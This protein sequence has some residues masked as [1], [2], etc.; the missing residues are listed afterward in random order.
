M[1]QKT[2]STSA[3]LRYLILMP[4]LFLMLTLESIAQESGSQET[5][6][7]I[8]VVDILDQ[9]TAENEKVQQALE[10]LKYGKP[11]STLIV[12]DGTSRIIYEAT[13][14][15]GIGIIT[16]TEELVNSTYV[17]SEDVPFAI[18][19]EVPVYPGCEDLTTNQEIKGCMVQKVT[20]HV[21]TNFNLGLAKDLPLTG[22]QQVYVQFKIDETGK[23]TAV[24]AR[25][26]APELER[27][28]IRVVE[29]LPQMLPG[30]HMGKPVSVMYSLPIKFILNQ[31]TGKES[32]AE[33]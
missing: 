29:A 5:T 30:K 10:D 32:G 25:A 9:T 33:E 24:R 28:A 31:D 26:P 19:E 22:M 18:I 2:R 15:S 12:T 27:E 17:K 11:Y 3:R 14:E 13:K 6:L 7:K 1:S 16:K 20:T 4:A 8:E 21:N 23:V